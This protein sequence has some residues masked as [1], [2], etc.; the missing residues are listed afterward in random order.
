[1]ANDKK[2]N[3]EQG[4][5]S[6]ITPAYNTGKLIH[7]L[8]DSVLAQ[9][10]PRV[11]M[12]VIDDG[13]T[14]NTREVV[15]SYI[16][17]FQQRGYHLS[18]CYQTNQ[19]QSA[20][21]N[22]GLK[23]V[24]GEYL[25]WP[26]SDDWY[27]RNDAFTTFV[28]KLNSLPDEYAMVRCIPTSVNEKSGEEKVLPFK[29]VYADSNQF[30]NCLYSRNFFWGAGNYM[31]RMSV[32]DHVNPKRD[33]YVQKDAGQNW[34]MLLPLMYRHQCYSFETSYFSVLE[35]ADSH[36][37]GQYHTFEQKLK[38]LAVYEDTIVRTLDRIIGLC[39]EDKQKYITTIK[40]KYLHER[41]ILSVKFG[42]GKK[43]REYYHQLEQSPALLITYRDKLFYVF[44]YTGFLFTF[45]IVV[46]HQLISFLRKL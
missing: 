23:M 2:E 14:D 11:E 45:I 1:M 8:L 9:D 13:S 6:V 31:V 12:F 5:I 46:L 7:R 24:N 41:F 36:S 15:E 10:Y 38:K 19:G 39:E 29:N 30:I 40:A 17:R 4:L 22:N 34:Q 20:A 26:D 44:S 35:R 37:R 3:M 43:V 33:I 16:L 42:K 18:Y 28:Q 21:V 27:N 32:F 25:I